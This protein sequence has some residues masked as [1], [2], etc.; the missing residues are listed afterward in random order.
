MAS[1]ISLVSSEYGFPTDPTAFFAW[2]KILPSKIK[3][4][5]LKS[6][7]IAVPEMTHKKLGP[8]LMKGKSS[9]FFSVSA[10][11]WFKL[12]FLAVW[13]Y[14]RKFG[15]YKIF[16]GKKETGKNDRSPKHSRYNNENK[17]MNIT[18]TK[19]LISTLTA[20]IVKHYREAT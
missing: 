15:T 14:L 5:K 11:K 6:Q 7:M 19:S 3:S 1:S 13:Y 8:I 4:I 17:S 12:L 18:S 16:V 9:Y 20:I 10:L 2:L